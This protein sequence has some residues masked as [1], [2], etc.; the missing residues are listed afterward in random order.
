MELISN[1][2][3]YI[4]EKEICMYANDH[5]I[6]ASGSSTCIVESIRLSESSKLTKWYKE[7]LPQV[8]VQKYQSMFTGPW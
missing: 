4:T 6:F 3:T 1:D 7:N 8:N 2:P 5:Q